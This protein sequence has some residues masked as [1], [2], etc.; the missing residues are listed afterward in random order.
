MYRKLK[1]RTTSEICLGRFSENVPK[2][3]N[4]EKLSIEM[5]LKKNGGGAPRRVGC[6]S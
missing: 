1:I 6:R 2:S 3:G 5:I 4:G